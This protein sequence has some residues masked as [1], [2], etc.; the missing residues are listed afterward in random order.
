MHQSVLHDAAFQHPD[1]QSDDAFIPDPVPQKLDHPVPVHPIEKALNVGFY[2]VAHFLLL[3]GPSEGIQALMLAAFRAVSMTTVLEYRLV[4]WFERSFSRC[5]NNLVFKI[6]DAQ[7]PPFR[8]PRLRNV[9]PAFRSRT[10]A[11]RGL[12][13]SSLDHCGTPVPITRDAAIPPPSF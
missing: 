6:A 3:D 12:A 2:D 11:Q 13:A 1:Y 4:D 5:L 10:V 8:A 7:R 9:A